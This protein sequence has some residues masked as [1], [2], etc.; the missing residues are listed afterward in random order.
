M[1]DGQDLKQS[2]HNGTSERRR[3]PAQQRSRERLERIL[4]VAS[5]LIASKGSDQVT[6][7]EIAELAEIS[8][9]SLYQYFPDKRSVIR[10]LAETHAEECHRCI[11]EAFADVHDKT[12]L[13]AAF[14]TLVDQYYRILL[15]NPVMRDVSYAM[16]ADKELAAVELAQSRSSAAL[17]AAAIQ[18]VFAGA[19]R[20]KL[21]VSSFL[22]WQLGEEALRLALAHEPR[23]A[24][25]LIGTYK[26]MS[27]QAIANPE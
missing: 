2:L 24:A 25:I 8:I 7:S 21:G 4:V 6:M 18:R 15:N 5:T 14:S 20:K 17:L 26:R 12:G 16:R 27:L 22:I 19:N 3:Q 13:L 23:E 9:G 1:R 11:E 10:S